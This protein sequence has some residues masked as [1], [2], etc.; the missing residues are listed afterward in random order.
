MVDGKVELIPEIEGAGKAYNEAGFMALLA[1]FEPMAAC[2]CPSWWPRPAIRCSR[3]PIPAPSPI[4]RWR[5]RPPTCCRSTATSEQRRLYMKPIIEGRYFG[6]MCLSE[7]QAGS[8]LADIKT[9]AEPQPDGSYRITGAKMW[10]SAGDHELGENIVHLVLAK[11]VGAP[12]AC[13]A[14]ACSSCRA[15][16]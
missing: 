16:A 13:A 1:D 10:I 6:T 3:R 9:Q 2:S 5:V 11:I 14:S 4:R 15:G 12:P 7:P 8:S